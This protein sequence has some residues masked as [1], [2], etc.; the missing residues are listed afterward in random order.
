MNDYNLLILSEKL[1]A[2]YDESKITDRESSYTEEFISLIG[3]VQDA[4]SNID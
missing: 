3:Q 4:V 1:L 2:L